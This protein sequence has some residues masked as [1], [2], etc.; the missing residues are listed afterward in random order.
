MASLS[1]A[2]QREREGGVTVGVDT[3]S[4]VHVAA[5]FTSDLGRPLGHLEIPTSPSGYQRLLRWAQGLG[6]PT[7]RFGIEGTGS[8]G[9]GLTR[10][11]RDAGCTVVEVNRPNRQT[12]RARGKSDPVDAEAAARAVLSGEAAGIPKADEDRVGMLRTLRVA[13]RSAVQSTTQ[14]T[15]QIKALLVT[16]PVELREQL[17]SVSGKALIATLAALRPGPVITPAAATKFTLRSLARRHQYLTDEIAALDAELDR[18]TQ[19]VAPALCALTGVG[20]NVAGALLVAAGDNPDR[21]R[22]EGSFAH[23]CGVAPLP[24]SS[25]KTT[26]RHRLNRGGDRQANNALWRIVMVRLAWHQ[27]TKDY[28]ARRTKEGLSKK[29]IIRCLKRYVAREVYGVLLPAH[30]LSVAA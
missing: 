10:F 24:A 26:G 20:T 23:L 30:R 5:A 6:D 25:G 15:N 17:R 7:P 11:L 28:M 3:H 2:H 12:R 27:P 29:E 22:S 1:M 21:M 18:L 13:R 8:Y 9:A 14:I 4:E 19:E 16:A